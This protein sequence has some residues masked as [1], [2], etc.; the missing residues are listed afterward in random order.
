VCV[1]E[2]EREEGCARR[3]AGERRANNT[4]SF[5]KVFFLFVKKERVR[6]FGVRGRTGAYEEWERGLDAE[7]PSPL[8]PALVA[9]HHGGRKGARLVMRGAVSCSHSC[10]FLPLCDPFAK[11]IP[12]TFEK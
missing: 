10:F 3:N 11:K 7:E 9:L 12:R 6:G 2:R 5:L 8:A 1:R 4:H